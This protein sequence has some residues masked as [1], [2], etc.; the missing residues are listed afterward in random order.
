[1]NSNNC[2]SL[3]TFV[4]EVNSKFSLIPKIFV[5][6]LIYLVTEAVVQSKLQFLPRYSFDYL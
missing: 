1:M 6:K 2:Y 4:N 3:L 5:Q